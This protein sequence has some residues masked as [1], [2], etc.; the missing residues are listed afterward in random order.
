MKGI[1]LELQ[2]A[3]S[4]WVLVGCE[5]WWCGDV[6]L[7]VV[8]MWWC[9]VCW[10]GDVWCGGMWCVHPICDKFRLKCTS[11]VLQMQKHFDKNPTE[12]SLI[13]I[14]IP[15]M[16]RS[17]KCLLTSVNWCKSAVK[18]HQSE[19]RTPHSFKNMAGE[20]LG[21]QESKDSRMI[22]NSHDDYQMTRNWTHYCIFN[23]R[24]SS[25]HNEEQ[26]EDSL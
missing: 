17:C 22:T 6:V 12:F 19:K 13:F 14:S 21:T 24:W 8:V 16:Q 7:C 15:F 11:S 5:V 25:G 3:W 4:C 10:F 23:S 20:T 2:T 18:G 26:M 1:I 9:V